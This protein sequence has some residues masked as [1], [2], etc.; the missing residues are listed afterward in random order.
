VS[1]LSRGEVRSAEEVLGQYHLAGSLAGS[2]VIADPTGELTRL[3][4]EVAAGY[5]KRRWV[6]RRC[7]HVRER[8]LTA[9]PLREED[10]LPDQVVA[11]L[12]PAGITTH[13]LLVAALRNPTVRRRYVA[14][15]EVLAEYG[16]LDRYPALLDL[17]GCAG[18]DRERVEHH[19]TALEELFDL[20]SRVVRT[21]FVFASDISAIARP[22]AIDGSRE[23]IAR[24][25]HREALFWMV[26]TACRCQTIL[27]ADAPGEVARCAP[28]YREL[29]G[30]LGVSSF[31]DLRRRKAEVEGLLP[32]VWAVAEAILAANPAIEEDALSPLSQDWER[33][34][35]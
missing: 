6:R 4:R 10:P 2:S 26:A 18:M 23:L 32:E 17:L 1:Y 30:D 20:A 8:L 12:F 21:P 13:L 9:F 27:A 15:R 25:H 35:G 19:L 16:H 24:G 3:Q 14:A 22:I 5:P 11:W 28:A 29:L 34:R 7:E 31:A 33:G